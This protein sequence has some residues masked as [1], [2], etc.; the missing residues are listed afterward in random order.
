M[1]VASSTTETMSGFPLA[2]YGRAGDISCEHV[3]TYL[4]AQPLV[5]QQSISFLYNNRN[6]DDDDDDDDVDDDD[7]DVDDVDDDARFLAIFGKIMVLEEPPLDGTWAAARSV[8]CGPTCNWEGK[9]P[10]AV[11]SKTSWPESCNMV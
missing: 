10:Q 2:C 4:L 9:H 11:D 7:D 3:P 6:D 1:A 5:L 8:S